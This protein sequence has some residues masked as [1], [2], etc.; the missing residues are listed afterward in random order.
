MNDDKVISFFAGMLRPVRCN[1][2]GLRWITDQSEGLAFCH[3][4]RARY[5]L[6]NLQS[7]PRIEREPGVGRATAFDLHRAERFLKPDM[8]RSSKELSLPVLERRQSYP[9]GGTVGLDALPDLACRRMWRCQYADLIFMRP[10]DG[11][12]K[13]MGKMWLAGG[14][15]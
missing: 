12:Q 2:Y 5:V 8:I 6:G 11:R 4:T 14:I 13:L 3:H 7:L 15:R 10:K 1:T 9:T